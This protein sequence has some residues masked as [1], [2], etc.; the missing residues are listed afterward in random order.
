MKKL[1]NNYNIIHI[2]DYNNVTL[3]LRGLLLIVVVIIFSNIATYQLFLKNDLSPTEKLYANRLYL[4]NKANKY[5]DDASAFERKVRSVS[6]DLDVAP[7]WLMSVMY[8]ESKF[9]AKV[10]N[11][12]GS[13]AVGLIQWMPSTARDLGTTTRELGRLSHTKQLDY[14]YKYLNNVKRKYGAF[15]SITDLYLA[16]LY[17]KALDGDYC[18]TLY[19]HPSKAYT[20][21]SILDENKDQ[22]VTVKDIDSRLKR[23]YPPAYQ[24]NY[25][26]KE[27]L[28]GGW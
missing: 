11:H 8:S 22:R 2:N 26:E 13:G 10:A 28:V 23:L 1:L 14:V 27:M 5:V 9:D 21:N 20:Q 19:A 12:K 18:Y 7:E 16:I 24:V 6:E 15:K 3:D 4:L 25:G 17:P